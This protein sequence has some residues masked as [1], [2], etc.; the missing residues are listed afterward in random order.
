[1]KIILLTLF[2]LIAC[3]PEK[4]IEQDHGHSH[5]ENA[6]EESYTYDPFFLD[7][8]KMH[9]EHEMKLAKLGMERTKDVKILN[10]TQL[11]LVNQ[12]K[13]VT[14]IIQWREEMYKKVPAVEEDKF[15]LDDLKKLK[16]AEFDKKFLARFKEMTV[17]GI[18]IS[19]MG[20]E[21]NFEPAI[22]SYAQEVHSRLKERLQKL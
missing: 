8:M 9:F 12:A 1:M 4:K 15:N 22:K 2:L 6:I 18:E 20:M 14:K 5:D 11:L 17:K 13:D 3:S 21:Q 7:V 16:G 10:F 19:R